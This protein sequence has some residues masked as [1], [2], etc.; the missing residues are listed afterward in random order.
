MKEIQELETQKQIYQLVEK[1]P[2][3]HLATIAE[4]LEITTPLLLY[5]LRYLQKHGL[6]IMEKE[7]GY[8]RCYIKGK[9]GIRDKKL[10]SLLRQHIPLRI[11]M[12]IL[13]H[14][15]AKHKEILKQFDLAKST[16]SYHLKKLQKHNIISFESV[17]G[18]QG[19]IIVDE[20]E[21][22]QCLLKYKPSRVAKGM[23]DTWTDFTVH[24][25][26]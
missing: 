22:I 11:I 10:L 7:K 18:E 13:Q 3:L 20:Q 26:K 19:F 4:R 1:Q 23:E 12:Y 8:T 14:P 24:S 16:L 15:Y 17:G 2:G 9:I 6:I 25:K 5:H 21:I